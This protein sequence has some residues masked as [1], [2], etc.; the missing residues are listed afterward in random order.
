MSSSHEVLRIISYLDLLKFTPRHSIREVQLSLPNLLNIPWQLLLSNNTVRSLM[1]GHTVSP[2]I[3]TESLAI[4]QNC[5]EFSCV[6]IIILVVADQ[7]PQ[8]AKA[9][10]YTTY[11]KSAIRGGVQ[12]V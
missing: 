4:V 8:K 1:E 6:D 12:H 11:V 2:K 7:D 9:T 10:P 5:T 3:S